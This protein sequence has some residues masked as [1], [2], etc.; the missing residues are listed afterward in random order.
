MRHPEPWY[1]ALAASLDHPGY[2][3]LAEI[4]QEE[5]RQARKSAATLKWRKRGTSYHLDLDGNYYVAGREPGKRT[6]QVQAWSVMTGDRPVRRQGGI[7]TMT[8]ARG[9]ALAM[10]CFVC[11]LANSLALMA[12]CPP[13]GMDQ[14]DGPRGLWK[15]LD[16]GPC[17]AERKRLTG[18]EDDPPARV[19][20]SPAAGHEAVTTPDGDGYLVTCPLGCNLGDSA[21][22]LTSLAAERRVNLHLHATRPLAPLTLANEIRRPVPVIRA[23]AAR[24]GPVPLTLTNE[25][26]GAS[27]PVEADPATG[28]MSLRET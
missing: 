24:P 2:V 14:A 22:A 27:F 11:G 7:R 20:I 26:T 28:R 12:P 17:E 19:Q 16:T 10:P 23:T 4:R 6:W 25:V 13:A 21:H 9:L 15:C 18:T 1:A 3:T 8:D 5:A